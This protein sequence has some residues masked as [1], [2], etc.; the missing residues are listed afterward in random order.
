MGEIGLHVFAMRILAFSSRF[1]Q[2][3]P[4]VLSRMKPTLDF[5]ERK[6]SCGER[7]APSSRYE[8]VSLPPTFL[9]IWMCS[10]FVEPWPY[11]SVRIIRDGKLLTLSLST[12]STARLAK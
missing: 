11:V 9:M 5:R 1:G 2:L 12:A 4:I 7:C 10:K 8:S 6:M 3:V